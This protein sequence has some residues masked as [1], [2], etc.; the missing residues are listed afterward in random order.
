MRLCI[1]VQPYALFMLESVSTRVWILAQAVTY[2]DPRNRQYTIMLSHV[3]PTYLLTLSKSL[4]VNLTKS[5]CAVW[6][7]FLFLQKKIS[8]N[9]SFFCLPVKTQSSLVSL[10]LLLFN[11]FVFL[12]FNIFCVS[13]LLWFINFVDLF[14]SYSED[15]LRNETLIVFNWYLK[16]QDEV[17]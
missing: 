1:T 13:S 16:A 9:W 4:L 6:S 5:L 12:Y 11:R 3:T 7:L 15:A 8:S 10:S 2:F 14:C 17:F